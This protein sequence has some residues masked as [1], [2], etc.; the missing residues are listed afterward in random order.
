MRRELS[1]WTSRCGPV[2]SADVPLDDLLWCPAQSALSHVFGG[3]INGD[4]M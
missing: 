3:G 1:H 2:P 4:M